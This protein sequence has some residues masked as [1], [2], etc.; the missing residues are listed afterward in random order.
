MTTE[1]TKYKICPECGKKN[2]P[3]IIECRYCEADLT[4]V[5]IVDDNIEQIE[6]TVAVPSIETERTMLVRICECGAENL[7]QTRKCKACGEVGCF[8]HC[9]DNGVQLPSQFLPLFQE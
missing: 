6:E 1:L 7:P 5:R 4:A 8:A 3:G 2:S 9:R